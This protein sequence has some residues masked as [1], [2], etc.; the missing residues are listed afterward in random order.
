[1]SKMCCACPDALCCRVARGPDWCYGVQDIG[2]E[3]EALLGGGE[4]GRLQGKDG[5]DSCVAPEWALPPLPAGGTGMGTILGA[6]THSGWCVVRC[7]LSCDLKGGCL[8]GWCGFGQENTLTHYPI[9]A[10]NIATPPVRRWDHD[11]SVNEY[12]AGHE[13]C[14]DLQVID[15]VMPSRK[16]HACPPCVRREG[17][18]M[19]R[20]SLP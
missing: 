13:E 10:L 19:P 16:A 20:F 6:S 12:R 2:K 9:P 18:P 15:E 5:P 14:Y 7:G 1:M 4:A 8:I 17:G 3:M 11:G